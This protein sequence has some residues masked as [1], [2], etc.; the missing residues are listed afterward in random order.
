M[1][2]NVSICEP[3]PELPTTNSLSNRS[4][5][6]LIGDVCQATQI[7][8]ALFMLPIHCISRGSNFAPGAPNSGANGTLECT[9]PTVVPS[10]GATVAK[11]VM[12]RM[13]PAPG[14]FCTTTCG[15]P[16]M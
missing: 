13:P 4:C 7:A 10:R 6:V 12:A 8:V 15:L 1:I 2:G 3:A 9:K 16:G 14:M 5:A 11:Y